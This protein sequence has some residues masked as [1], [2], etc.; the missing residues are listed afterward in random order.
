MKAVR[1]RPDPGH[2]LTHDFDTMVICE[3]KFRRR[4]SNLQLALH[5]VLPEIVDGPAGVSA[6]IKRAWLTDIQSQHALFVLHQVLR[7]FTDDHVV[8]HPNDLWLKN[9]VLEEKAILMGRGQGEGRRG[10]EEGAYKDSEGCWGGQESR[11]RRE[12]R[13]R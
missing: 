10:E 4:T 5:L 9:S 8:L 1:E 2:A 7:V 6:P 12:E 3:V 13:E 11:G